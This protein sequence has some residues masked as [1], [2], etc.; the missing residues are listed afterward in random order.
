M[1][2]GQIA[3]W[4][5]VIDLSPSR[6]WDVNPTNN[7]LATGATF[8]DP[9]DA[10]FG[11]LQEWAAYTAPNCG[12]RACRGWNPSSPKPTK[13]SKACCDLER[14]N[15]LPASRPARISARR[16]PIWPG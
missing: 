14:S 5:L 9:P 7:G 4:L 15:L 16:D 13:S 11:S 12:A 8:I 2:Q 6:R 3:A 1:G 10:V